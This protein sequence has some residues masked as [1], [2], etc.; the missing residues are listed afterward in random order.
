MW[1]IYEKKY[2]DAIILFSGGRIVRCKKWDKK[3]WKKFVG[4]LHIS[5]KVPTFA[6]HLREN[7]SANKVDSLAQQVEHIP[8]KDGVLG[9]SPR[10][11]TK[12]ELKKFLF[13]SWGI[14][15]LG[16]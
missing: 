12:K 8:F 1:K 10:R 15:I 3:V 7:L 9:S 5:K 2:F 16:N 11:I 6:S 4:Y 14:F 13:L